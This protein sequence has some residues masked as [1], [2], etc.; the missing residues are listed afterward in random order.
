MRL[1]FAIIISFVFLSS[2]KDKNKEYAPLNNKPKAHQIKVKEVL[3][4]ST[5]TYLFVNENKEEY[6]IAVSKADIK[7]DDHLYYNKALEMK[8]FKSEELDRTFDRILFVEDLGGMK[9]KTESIPNDSLHNKLKDQEKKPIINVDIAPDGIRIAELMKNRDNYTNK[10][11]IIRGQVVK[12]NAGIMDRNWVHLKDGTSHSGKSDLTFTT[13]EEVKV[14]DIVTFEGTV[15][16]D[17]E[18]GAGYIYPLIVENAIL[19]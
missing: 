16:L 7:V 5:Y 18:Y 4:A 13:H 6:W 12:I 17:K 14:G 9:L 15:A 11:I 2:C 19:K 3:Q 8:D 1:V 10:K